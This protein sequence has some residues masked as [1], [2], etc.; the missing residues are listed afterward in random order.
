[1]IKLVKLTTVILLLA[2]LVQPTLGLLPQIPG[3]YLGKIAMMQ[4]DFMP[5]VSTEAK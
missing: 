2:V 3:L 4:I 1:M 5:G